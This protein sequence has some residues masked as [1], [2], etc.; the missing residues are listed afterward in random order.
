M[1]RL[2]ADMAKAIREDQDTVTRKAT[3]S[4]VK[5]IIQTRIKEAKSV[6]DLFAEKASDIEYRG[7]IRVARES[8]SKAITRGLVYDELLEAIEGLEKE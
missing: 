1:D 2:M 5:G 3:L 4:E 7:D 8:E 6:A